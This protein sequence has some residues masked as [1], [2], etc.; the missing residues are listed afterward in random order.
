MYQDYSIGSTQLSTHLMRSNLT[1]LNWH[2]HI[3]IRTHHTWSHSA[4]I[5]SQ[6]HHQSIPVTCFT[7]SFIANNDAKSSCCLQWVSNTDNNA[8]ENVAV[9]RICCGNAES[10]SNPA[11]CSLE[12]VFV[13]LDPKDE[14]LGKHFSNV[15]SK[16]SQS[17]TACRA[18]N[19][20]ACRSSCKAKECSWAVRLEDVTAA[21]WVSETWRD[22]HADIRYQTIAKVSEHD[23]EEVC[24]TKG[25][26]ELIE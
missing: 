21:R 8:N 16:K 12:S 5:I 17:T 10:L 7:I 25:E 15:L 26:K 11:L 13:K 18:S 2:I 19:S 24:T 23:R 22:R 1:T 4:N 9:C 14:E 6:K 20:H 3:H